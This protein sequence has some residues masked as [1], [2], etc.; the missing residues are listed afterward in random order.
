MAGGS[1]SG[2]RR[3]RRPAALDYT[4]P[5]W[6]QQ[7]GES[8]VAFAQF[9]AYRDSDPRRVRDHASG[10][11]NSV[12]WSWRERVRA[13]DL[14]LQE[15]ETERLI[16]YRVD[17]NERHRA[18]ARLAMSRAAQW[19]QGLDETRISKMRPGEVMKMLEVAANLERNAS[20]GNLPDVTV[21]V[22]AGLVDMTAKATDARL[23]ELMREVQRRREAAAAP[24]VP[25]IAGPV[26]E[27]GPEDDGRFV[28]VVDVD[29]DGRV[30]EVET[31]D[32]FDG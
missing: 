32:G 3:A 7:A 18:V 10:F 16:R 29:E 24:E 20:R 4:R 6:Y 11:H 12:R 17:M 14:H 13:W 15:Q 8:D 9:E 23:D 30:V 26:V 25:R 31:G 28:D 5:I 19:L 27:E 1:A 22:T 21:G 2:R